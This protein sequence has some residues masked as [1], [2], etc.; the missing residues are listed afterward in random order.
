[1]L[2]DAA[3]HSQ[4]CSQFDQKPP[5]ITWLFY[6]GKLQAYVQGEKNTAKNKIHDLII[7]KL[8]VQFLNCYFITDINFKAN[9]NKPVDTILDISA[10]QWK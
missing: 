3:G 10:D 9:T 6:L 2:P 7:L 4:E 1:M 8:H 5:W